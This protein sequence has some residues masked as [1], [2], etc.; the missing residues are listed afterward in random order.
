MRY[1][2]CFAN[3]LDIQEGG[4][5]INKDGRPTAVLPKP[6]SILVPWV[7]HTLPAHKGCKS[8]MCQLT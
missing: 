4:Q 8:L 2:L 5:S 3:T 6:L 7:I 1:E